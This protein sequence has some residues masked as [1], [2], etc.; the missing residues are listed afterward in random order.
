MELCCVSSRFVE[1][2]RKDV[3]IALER[4]VTA[5]S[6]IAERTGCDPADPHSFLTEGRK[7]REDF[8]VEPLV[9]LLKKAMEELS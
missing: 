6:V 1:F 8:L 4:G 7:S 5:G 9:K 3:E 2:P